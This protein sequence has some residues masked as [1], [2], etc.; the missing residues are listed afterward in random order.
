MVIYYNLIWFNA[1][2]LACACILFLRLCSDIWTVFHILFRIDSLV[3]HFTSFIMPLWRTNQS[4]ANRKLKDLLS[5]VR[6][7]VRTYSVP[8]VYFVVCY[9][10]ENVIT[11]SK[12]IIKST[13]LELST[14]NHWLM[15]GLFVF[16]RFDAAFNIVFISYSL[17]LQWF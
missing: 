6:N 8:F 17:S 13:T 14:T 15:A 1:I 11:Q 7:Y 10:N 4:C 2:A 3:E 16:Y 12:T 9:L 5:Y